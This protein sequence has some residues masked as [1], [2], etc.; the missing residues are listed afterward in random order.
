MLPDPTFR[1]ATLADAANLAVLVDMAGK[2]SR[3]F[4]GETWRGQATRR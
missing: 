1:P 3:A 4:S 2:G